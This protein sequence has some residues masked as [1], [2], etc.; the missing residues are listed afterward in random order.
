[1]KGASVLIGG[2]GGQGVILT[3]RILAEAA[4]ALGLGAQMSE[5]HGMSQR[6]G[7]VVSNVRFGKAETPLVKRGEADAIVGFE[8]LETVRLLPWAY[9]KTVIVTSIT[10]I[11]P[12]SV[13]LGHEAYPLLEDLHERLKDRAGRVI[14]IDADRIARSI[15]SEVV[16]NSVLLGALIGTKVL[17]IPLDSVRKTLVKHV[18]SKL[19]TPNLEALDIGYGVAIQDG[20]SI[21]F[22]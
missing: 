1:M 3:A 16:A 12:L 10:P 13:S 20:Y 4:L 2:V 7:S 22:A 17:P 14:F 9:R 19:A 6:Y 21:A 15:G 5:I 8:P 11:R 18:P